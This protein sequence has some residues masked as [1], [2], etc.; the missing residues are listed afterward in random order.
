MKRRQAGNTLVEYGFIGALILVACIAGVTM[1]GGALK[2]AMVNVGKD[3]Q[4]N[5]NAA[6]T[7]GGNCQGQNCGGVDS[8]GF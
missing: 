4:S 8:G 1:I 7:S 6:A 5:I 2:G 3:F